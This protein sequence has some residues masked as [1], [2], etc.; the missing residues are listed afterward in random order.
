MTASTTRLILRIL[1]VL[2]ATCV[3]GFVALMVWIR[4]VDS[5]PVGTGECRPSPDQRYQAC[6]HSY[7][8]TDFW[9]GDP[10]HWFEFGLSGPDQSYR[11]TTSP[12]PG[13]YFGSRSSHRVVFWQ[14]DSQAVRFVFPDATLRIAT[15][16]EQGE[17][18]VT[19]G[20]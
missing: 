20:P 16:I 10:R 9:T 17:T 12:I 7:T 19:G 4:W 6:V 14:P 18:P 1:A 15:S 3:L 8:A 2:A 5:L 13:P 11:M